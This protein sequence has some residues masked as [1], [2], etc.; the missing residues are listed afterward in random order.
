MCCLRWTHDSI[1]KKMMF[2]HNGNNN[3]NIVKL[4]DQLQRG[5]DELRMENTTKL[6]LRMSCQ[7]CSMQGYAR[8]DANAANRDSM[9]ITILIR[10]PLR[11]V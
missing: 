5:D 4:I 8:F 6:E 10:R 3:E 1:N 7:S 11:R 2:G 9:S